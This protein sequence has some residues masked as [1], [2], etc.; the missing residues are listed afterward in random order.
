MGILFPERDTFAELMESQPV[1]QCCF[2]L[3][4]IPLRIVSKL[5]A[6]ANWT[7]PSHDQSDPKKESR[8]ADTSVEFSIA[9]SPK[10]LSDNSL[11][12]AG[13]AAPGLSIAAARSPLFFGCGRCRTGDVDTGV[14]GKMLILLLIFAALLSRGGLD[15]IANIYR[16]RIKNPIWFMQPNRVFYLPE[17]R[18]NI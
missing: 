9:A 17:C 6:D 12:F 18:G 16:S 10:Q 4:T 5:L 2:A 11:R 8:A 14:Y 3:S 1:M 15:R 7:T 13:P